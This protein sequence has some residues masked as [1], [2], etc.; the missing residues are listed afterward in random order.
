MQDT[1][2]KRNQETYEAPDIVEYYAQLK[3]LQ[4]A[5][6]AICDRLKDR[7]PGMKMLDLGIGG[8]RTTQHFAPLVAEYT[9]IDYSE[10]MIA[11]CRKK[12]DSSSPTIAL[13]VGDARNLEQFA[14]DSFDFV[15]FSFNGIDYVIDSDRLKI[16][17]EIHRVSKPGAYFY[18]SSHNLQGIAKE[19]AW[20]KQ[21]ALNPLETYT[22]LVMAGL[23]RFFNPGTTRDRLKNSDHLMIRDEPHNFRLWNYYIRPEAQIAQLLQAGFA[24]IEVYSWRTG[25]VLE[26]SDRAANLDLWLYYFCKVR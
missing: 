2:A 3:L 8:G 6:V 15:L 13:E 12:F 1:V 25:R 9:G 21:L 10:R 23:L 5:E 18:F 17:Q 7:L 20:R 22:N 11:A 14:S 26:A 24:D 19:F 4:P 16:L